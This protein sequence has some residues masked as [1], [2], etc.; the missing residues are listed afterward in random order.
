MGVDQYTSTHRFDP[1]PDGGRIALQRDTDDSAG[2][3]R[4]RAHLREIAS[5]FASGDFS[6]PSFVHASAS[7]P[8]T[9][10]MAEKRSAIRFQMLELPRGGEVRL[11]TLDPLAVAAI[12]EFLAFQRSDHRVQAKGSP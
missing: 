12:H 10:V 11:T 7:V 8:G 6:D 4:I 2:A 5:R 3:A 1:L 9:R